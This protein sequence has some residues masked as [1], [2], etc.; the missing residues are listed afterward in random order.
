M[1]SLN[2]L[3]NWHTDQSDFADEDPSVGG[4]SRGRSMPLRTEDN[5]FRG[6]GGPRQ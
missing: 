1:T 3:M 4:M 6:A 2:W 5:K